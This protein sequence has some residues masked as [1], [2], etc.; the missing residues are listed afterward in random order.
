MISI[1]IRSVHS[2]PEQSQRGL[3]Q[4]IRCSEKDLKF[5]SLTM[6][7]LDF[8]HHKQNKTGIYNLELNEEIPFVNFSAG[9][10]PKDITENWKSDFE[11]IKEISLSKNCLALGE[12]GL[13]GLIDIDEKLQTKCS[14]IILPGQKKLENLLS[15]IVSADFRKFSISKKQKCR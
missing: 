2:Y 11:R 8:H 12:C 9:L 1:I 10:H 5:I 3:L 15:S 14:K 7:F 4:A 6:D 13:D